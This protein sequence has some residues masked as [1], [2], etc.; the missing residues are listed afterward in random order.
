MTSTLSRL[1]RFAKAAKNEA[2][3]NFTTEALA[4][5][6]RTEPE[7]FLA[8]FGGVHVSSAAVLAVE[9][10]VPVPAIGIVDLVVQIETAAGFD[11]VWVEVKVDAGESGDQLTRYTRYVEALPTAARP[12]LVVLGPKPIGDVPWVAWQQVRRSIVS[13]NTRNPS[14]LDFK[15]YLEEIHMADDYS[16]PISASEAGA[17]GPAHAL[18]GK[19]ARILSLFADAA[20]K[21]WPAS[22]WLSDETAIR[23]R[24]A[25]SLARWGALNVDARTHFRAGIGVGAYQDGPLGEAMLGLWIYAK[26]N[27]VA[28]RERIS[29]Q[30]QAGGLGP[31]WASSPAD[32]EFLGTYRRLR[33]F[34]TPE[35]ASTWLGDC[36]LDLDAAGVL[37]MLPKL[38]GMSPEEQ[39]EVEAERDAEERSGTVDR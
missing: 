27:W 8:A 25:Q 19:V 15:R 29:R 20:Q 9:T 4:A 33:D 32:W 34:T 23:K 14:W 21:S 39:A 37:A 2:R 35:A 11:T 24:L 26:P 36:L 13:T 17:L 5:A 6:I 12:R 31:H 28:D 1:F 16:E 38:G 3:E 30:A 22:R 18:L 10:Q 7:P